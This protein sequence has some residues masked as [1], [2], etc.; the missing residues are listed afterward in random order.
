MLRAFVHLACAC[1]VSVAAVASAQTDDAETRAWAH[2]QLGRDAFDARHYERAIKEFEIGYR[3]KPRPILLY[4]IARAAELAGQPQKALDHYRLYLEMRP[5]APER[6]EVQ[7]HI[8]A[9]EQQLAAGN[10]EHA[11][12]PAPEAIVAG[13]RVAPKKDRHKLVIALSV[14]GAALVVGAAA[15]GVTVANQSQPEFHPW[16]TL[17]VTPH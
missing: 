14:V 13:P 8:G 17:A 15:V 10:D 3:N 16:G 9:L 4:N 2:E 11:L 5:Q 1:L 7:R 6:D 12:T